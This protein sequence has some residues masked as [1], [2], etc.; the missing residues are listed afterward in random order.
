MFSHLGVVEATHPKGDQDLEETA[1]EA[2]A[3]EVETLES[4]DLPEGG[5][6]GR[7]LCAIPALNEV[8]EALRAAGW[9][10]TTSE[11]T[12]EVQNPVTVSDDDLPTVTE[13]LRKLDDNDDTH[14][15]Y[16]GLA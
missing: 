8:N 6:G 11:L 4:D 16:S 13:F 5:I 15:I 12:Y 1:I 14:R 3:D 7:F 10:I 9:T 2:G